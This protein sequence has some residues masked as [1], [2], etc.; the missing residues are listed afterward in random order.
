MRRGGDPESGMVGEYGLLACHCVV[1]ECAWCYVRTQC[2]RLSGC[3]E[4]RQWKGNHYIFSGLRYCI[5]MEL[6]MDGGI[7]KMCRECVIEEVS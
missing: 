6:T 4:R 1:D 5:I 2:L 3:S 7:R